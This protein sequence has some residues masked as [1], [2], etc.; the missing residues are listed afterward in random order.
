[1]L[2]NMINGNGTFGVPAL[3]SMVTQGN[4]FFVRPTGG[5]DGNDGK[6]PARA[7]KTLVK[8]LQSCSANQNDTIYLIAESN[9]ASATTAYLT[10]QLDWNKD[11]VHLIGVGTGS[12]IG[13]RARIAVASTTVLTTDMFKLSAN[14]CII[15][16][17]GF[18]FGVATTTTA[19][20]AAINVTGARNYLYNCS[21]SGIGHADM[22]TLG[23]SS[24]TLNGAQENTFEKCYIGLD[25][26]TRGVQVNTEINLKGGAV[27][28]IFKDCIIAAAAS[29]NTHTWVT[30][31][32][33]GIDR[34]VDFIGC[35]FY[36]DTLS[37]GVN[38][39]Q[40]LAVTAG[41]SPNGMILLK[42]CGLVGATK[43]ET[44]ASGEVYSTCPAPGS[45]TT[46]GIAT[47][48]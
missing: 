43:W 7:F 5:S 39:T 45:S 13:Q 28:N 31:A 4:V 32:S 29:V 2:Q 33:A 46:S 26:V 8:A 19:G 37:V 42:D 23:S 3:G 40:G 21:V 17:I 12:M 24:L 34:F 9:T 47:S 18:F 36:N 6:S 11:L 30:K 10:A 48:V 44:T 38:M 27:R 15:S 1:M 41:G 22:D 16:N 35:V 20:I 25:T 14:G